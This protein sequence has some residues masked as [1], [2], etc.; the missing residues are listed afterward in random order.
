MMMIFD[1]VDDDNVVVFVQHM[2][3]SE[4]DL[5]APDAADV[6][7]NQNQPLIGRSLSASTSLVEVLLDADKPLA[8][9]AAARPLT[10]GTA[11]AKPLTYD[12]AAKTHADG[13]PAKPLTDGARSSQQQHNEVIR[14]NIHSCLVFTVLGY[15]FLSVTVTD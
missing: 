15:N 13:A 4:Q 3:Q 12:A 2:D 9:G 5:T 14:F 6:S 7:A 1:V 10:Y 8:D 11:A